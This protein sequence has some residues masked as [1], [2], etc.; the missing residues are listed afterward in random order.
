[1]EWTDVAIMRT[2]YNIIPSHKRYPSFFF[3][4][5]RAF[6]PP[7][8]PPP[9]PVLANESSL[10]EPE[11]GFDSYLPARPQVVDPRVDH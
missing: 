3:P 7:P 9:L 4:L 5:P 2:A 1:M 6:N 11:S 8:P 10:F